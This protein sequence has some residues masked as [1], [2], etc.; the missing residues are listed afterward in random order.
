MSAGV[1]YMVEGLEAVAWCPRR[2]ADGQ[3]LV[4]EVVAAHRNTTA[5]VFYNNE[6]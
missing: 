4:P 1:R 2:T 5:S 6:N 3:G